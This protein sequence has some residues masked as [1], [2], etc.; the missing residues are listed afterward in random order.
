MMA[1][2]YA[3]GIKDRERLNLDKGDT[4]PHS[5]L[6]MAGRACLITVDTLQILLYTAVKVIP[7]DGRKHAGESR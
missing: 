2:V 3:L 1:S 4:S 5:R 6:G 7:L